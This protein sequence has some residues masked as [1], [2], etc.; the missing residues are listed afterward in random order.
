MNQSK[1]DQKNARATRAKRGKSINQSVNQSTLFNEGDTQQSS[2]DK[3]VALEIPDR[4]G[5]WNVGF[6]GG[7]KTGELRENMHT[8]GDSQRGEGMPVGATAILHLVLLGP[9][10]LRRES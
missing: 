7:S 5:I 10:P 4:I 6:S 8:V 1:L 9:S 3:P 2:T